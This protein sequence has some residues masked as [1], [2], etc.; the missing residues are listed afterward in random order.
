[1]LLSHEKL[2]IKKTLGTEDK[3]YQINTTF[4]TVVEAR[5]TAP[6]KCKAIYTVTMALSKTGPNES[7]LASSLITSKI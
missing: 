4:P 5:N 6:V 1:M 7:T 2:K 3:L